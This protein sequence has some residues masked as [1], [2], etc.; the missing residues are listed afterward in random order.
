MI[1]VNKFDNFVNEA[2]KTGYKKSVGNV[3]VKK[4]DGGWL[5]TTPSKLS[6]GNQ[7]IAFIDEQIPDLLKIL[8]TGSNFSI[9]PLDTDA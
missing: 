5:L 9:Q 7:V 8:A 4:V 1:R 2:L 3:E 6:K